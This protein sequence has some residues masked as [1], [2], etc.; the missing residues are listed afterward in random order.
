MAGS[1]ACEA[2]LASEIFP[3]LLPWGHRDRVAEIVCSSAATTRR[4][5]RLLLNHG[6]VN[7]PWILREPHSEI[8]G[9][10]HLSESAT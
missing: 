7:F 2:V 9:D 5:V 1:N 3:L 4:P 8:D 6:R 10:G